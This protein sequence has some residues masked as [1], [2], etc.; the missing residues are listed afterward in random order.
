MTPLTVHAKGPAVRVIVLVTTE[1]IIGRCAVFPNLFLM[2]GPA[3]KAL[4]LAVK[5]IIR[6][7]AVVERP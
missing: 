5:F 2:T 6:L 7:L 4:V 1:T 3:G